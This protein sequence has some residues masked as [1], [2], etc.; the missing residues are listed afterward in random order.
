MYQ[1]LK[2]ITGLEV[3]QNRCQDVAPFSEKKAS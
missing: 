3:G 2:G 1:G